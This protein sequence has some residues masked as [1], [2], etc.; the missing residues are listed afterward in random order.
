MMQH[1]ILIDPN[2]ARLQPITDF[3]RRIQIRG[4]D[5]SGESIGGFIADADGV[6]EIGEAGDGADRAEDFVLHDFHGGRDVAEDG[7]L[8]EVAGAGGAAAFSAG[9]DGGAFGFAGGDVAE[10]GVRALAWCQCTSSVGFG[11]ENKKKVKGCI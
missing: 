7:G 8:D 6:V 11:E 3:N 5:C 10:K 9:F 1:I 4:M 2:R